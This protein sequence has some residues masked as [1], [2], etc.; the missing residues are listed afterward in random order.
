MGDIEQ[1]GCSIY[2]TLTFLAR[3]RA[4]KQVLETPLPKGEIHR[5]YWTQAWMNLSLLENTLSEEYE[6]LTELETGNE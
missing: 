6:R 4:A 3:V 2:Y 5:D 1:R